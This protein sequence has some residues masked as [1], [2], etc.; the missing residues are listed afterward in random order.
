M[1]T[2]VT[3][4]FVRHAETMLNRMERVQ[5][6]ANAPLTEKGIVDTHRSGRGLKDIK[7]DAIY[8]SD[9][10][11]TIETAQI[12]LEENNHAHQLEIHPMTEFRE[13]N[14]GYYEGLDANQLWRDVR[15]HLSTVYGIDQA[16]QIQAEVFLNTIHELDPYKFAEDY[17]TF[18]MRV[19]S[20]LLE[21]LNSHAGTNETILIVSHGMTIQNLL[22]GLVADF[23]EKE[24]LNNASVSV[25]QYID[26]QFKL[27]KYNDTSHFTDYP[28]LIPTE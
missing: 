7:F 5:G 25:V 23:H 14:F 13:V 22:N 8:T 10:M 1:S 16:E 19:E 9:L 6:W 21:L 3:F 18:W 15:E 2:G 24:R 28:S 4:Y 11:R 27:L 17:K 20:G 12:L 26:G